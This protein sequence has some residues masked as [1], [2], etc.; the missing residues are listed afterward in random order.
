MLYAKVTHTP[1]KNYLLSALFG[2]ALAPLVSEIS[3]N[4]GLPFS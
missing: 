2:T 4:I 1:F 3:F